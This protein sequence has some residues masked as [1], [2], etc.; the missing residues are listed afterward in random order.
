MYVITGATGHTGKRISENLL[1][2]WKPV[3][4]I[5]RS[6]D[7]GADLVS[8]GAVAAVSNLSDAA[9]LTNALQGSTAVALLI[10]P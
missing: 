2:A 5:S 10:P 3:K 8:Q 1:A 7:K 6:A 4:V 9:C